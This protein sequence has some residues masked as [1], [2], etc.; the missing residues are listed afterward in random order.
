METLRM[1]KKE[2]NIVDVAAAPDVHLQKLE[3]NEREMEHC[4]Q[5]FVGVCVSL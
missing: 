1:K 5:H 4:K 2:R 3:M